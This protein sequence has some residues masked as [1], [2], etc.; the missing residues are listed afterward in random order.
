MDATFDSL[1]SPTARLTANILITGHHGGRDL[2]LRT[3]RASGITLTGHLIGVSDHRARF[4]SDL[5]ESLAWGDERYRQLMD[6]VRKLVAERDIAPRTSR[7]RVD[8]MLVH[9]KASTC[10]DSALQSSR[11]GSDP[12][13]ARG[14]RGP[15][16]SRSLDS[17]CNETAR[18]R[19]S[20]VC[21]F[22]VSTSSA[23]ASHRSLVASARMR[24]LWLATSHCATDIEPT[25]SRSRTGC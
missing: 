23:S 20:R 25:G 6:L 15:K 18:V 22:W 24:R 9:P 14:Y 10:R 13:T 4:A 7:S 19:L 5:P 17:P 16:H 1:P 8:S 12:T 11:Q 2:N 3:L 21:I